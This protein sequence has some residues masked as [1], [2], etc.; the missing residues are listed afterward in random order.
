MRIIVLLM[1]LVSCNTKPTVEQKPVVATSQVELEGIPP[2]AIQE[3]FT[4]AAGMVRVT[5][6]DNGGL[7][8]ADGTY[9][10]GKREGTWTEYT[11]SGLVKS[12]TSYVNGEKEGIYVEMDASGQMVKRFYY[13]KWKRH[14][15]YKE[16]NYSTLKED[17][18]YRFQ[19]VERPVRL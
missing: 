5:L 16:F 11:T 14:G 12:L 3:E 17:K 19:K 15:E 13:H 10:N 7:K 9:V 8:S 6:A 2:G 18:L 1:V 4:D